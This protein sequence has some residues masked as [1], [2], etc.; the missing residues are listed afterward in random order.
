MLVML[1]DNGRLSSKPARIIQKR[2]KKIAGIS[3]I[4]CCN[5]QIFRGRDGGVQGSEAH[6]YG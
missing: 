4:V 1:I 6:D 5:N 2:R 3:Q